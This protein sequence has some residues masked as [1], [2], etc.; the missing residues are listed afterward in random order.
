M[1]MESSAACEE[2]TPPYAIV[3]L[4]ADLL[5]RGGRQSQLL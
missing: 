4:R 1:A 2:Q 5:S 3:T